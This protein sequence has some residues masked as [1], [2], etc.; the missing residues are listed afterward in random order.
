MPNH[1][2]PNLALSFNLINHLNSWPFYLTSQ[3]WT[4]I[5]FPRK[6]LHTPETLQII[7]YLILMDSHICVFTVLF[8]NLDLSWS[9]LMCWS[10]TTFYKALLAEIRK[11]TENRKLTNTLKCFNLPHGFI[12]HQTRITLANGC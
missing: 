7:L 11:N 12:N 6:H 8:G 9:S 1:L 3:I 4:S 5:L 10:Q 2:I